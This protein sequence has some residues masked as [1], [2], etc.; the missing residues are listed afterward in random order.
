ML[1]NNTK[2]IEISPYL[3]DTCIEL[4]AD[5]L[6]VLH[7]SN[8]PDTAQT[9]AILYCIEDTIEDLSQLFNSNTKE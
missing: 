7:K 9:E 8:L 2:T 1:I 6:A 3:L 5:Y 4:L